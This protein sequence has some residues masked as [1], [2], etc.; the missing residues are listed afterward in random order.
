[1]VGV[2]VDD[3]FELPVVGKLQRVFAQVQGDAGAAI[4][5]VDSLDFKV[6][7]AA[8]DPTHAFA[9][10]N[11]RAARFDGDFVSDDKARVKAHA[12]LADELA[13]V[14]RVAFLRF[15][16]APHK[17]FG[18]AFGNRAQVLDGLLRR[19]ADAVIAD[20][21]G[22][23][24]VADAHFQFAVALVQRVVVQRFKAQLVASV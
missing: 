21:D 24:I 2:F 16:Q 19:H 17:V 13:L 14:L 1:M 18:A 22:F 3:G 15:A 6:A 8:A 9:R 7:T 23:V 5:F 4:G 12:K 10:G 20:G 11:A